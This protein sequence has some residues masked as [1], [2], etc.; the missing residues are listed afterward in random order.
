[1]ENEFLDAFR[2]NKGSLK[3]S[4]KGRELYWR[5]SWA[6]YSTEPEMKVKL[7]EWYDDRIQ[8]LTEGSTLPSSTGYNNCTFA[9]EEDKYK[10]YLIKEKENLKN[11]T[12]AGQANN[13]NRR[14]TNGSISGTEAI[15]N[16]VDYSEF[17]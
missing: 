3:E 7:I 15:I 1:M 17:T 10:E 13:S 8:V 16:G 12:N 5:Y 11:N 2:L 6:I 14:N 9:D 4:D